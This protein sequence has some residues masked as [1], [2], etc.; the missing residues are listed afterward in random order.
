MHSSHMATTA[1]RGRH[2]LS[3]G[4]VSSAA[5]N[6]SSVVLEIEFG[7]QGPHIAIMGGEACKQLEKDDR[8]SRQLLDDG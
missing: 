2:R 5:R 4:I 6:G 1:M 8:V 7:G 3:G